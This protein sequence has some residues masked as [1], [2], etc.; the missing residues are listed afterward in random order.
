MA[1]AN[2]TA[3]YQ[4]A[5]DLFVL[6]LSAQKNIPREFRQCIG[7]RLADDCTDMLVLIGRANKAFGAARVPHL[8]V[9]AERIEGVTVLLRGASRTRAISSGTWSK[10]IE[11][12]TSLGKQCSG[13]L[14]N[15]RQ[16]HGQ[17]AHATPAA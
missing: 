2:D 1:L 8:E 14:K 12:T 5:D 17:P 4:T 7:R 13:W 9:L 3:I 15:T 16:A 11:L 10:S 6:V